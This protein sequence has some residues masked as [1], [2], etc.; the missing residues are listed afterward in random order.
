MRA[1]PGRS[2]GSREEG[3]QAIDAADGDE[4]RFRACRRS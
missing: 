1:T 4:R 2:G 3:R